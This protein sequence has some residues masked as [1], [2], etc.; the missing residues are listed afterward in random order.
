MLTII[1]L[2]ITYSNYKK[3]NTAFCLI[4]FILTIVFFLLEVIGLGV[5]I[6]AIRSLIE[7]SNLLGGY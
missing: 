6:G 5:G 4:L 2:A 1:A 3:Y 7:N